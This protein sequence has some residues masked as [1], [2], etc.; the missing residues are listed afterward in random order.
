M[1]PPKRLAPVHDL[2]NVEAVV[3]QIGQRPSPKSA[4]ADDAAGR[5]LALL[6]AD[7]VP[8]EFLR[9]GLHRAMR[10]IAGE[11]L[12]HG[13]RLA[14]QHDHA[15]VH[16]RIAERHRPANPDALALGGRD[17]VAHPL[18][19]DLALEL[20][21][22]QQDVEREPAHAGRGIEGLC[23]RHEG[24]RV[25]IEQLDQ[26]GEIGERAGQAVDLVH[27]H[28]IDAAGLHCGKQ[29]LQGGPVERGAGKPAVIVA[30]GHRPP[31]LA[32]LAA[33]IGFA[34]FALGIERRE[35]KQQF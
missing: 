26:L 33:D 16:R 24:H 12:A 34:G 8:V 19:D 3:Q 32:G 18:A 21:E 5:E 25:S 6:A 29:R 35:G 9:Q 11:D 2:A 17:L 1:I 7:A 23:H 20:G 15:L 27:H 10:E 30:A 31:A 14:R 13:F 4:A 22:G 28:D